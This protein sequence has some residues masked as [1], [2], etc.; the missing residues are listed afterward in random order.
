MYR[1]LSAMLAVSLTGLAL[2]ACGN[3]QPAQQDGIPEGK[4]VATPEQL[5]DIWDQ[6]VALP[7]EQVN[8]ELAHGVA[9]DIATRGAEGIA[10]L[11]RKLDVPAPTPQMVVLSLGVLRKHIKPEH[12]ALLIELAG[13]EKSKA[14][15]TV[16]IDLL[17]SIETPTATAKLAELSNDPDAMIAVVA[18][19]AH[20]PTGDAA[21][22][23]RINSFWDN[24]AVHDSFRQ[25]LM[26]RL[27]EA[28][29][30]LAVGPMCA[31]VTRVDWPTDVRQRVI[32]L[33]GFVNDP[34]AAEALKQAAET[35]P[36][37]ELR[38]Y[39]AKA[40][41]A[42]EA[43]IAAGGEIQTVEVGPDGVH[44]AVMP[45]KAEPGMPD[46]LPAPGTPAPAPAAEPAPA[47]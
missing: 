36:E 12:E 40:A 43:R 34:R 33:L 42:A 29:T 30:L 39:A 17:G 9:E 4:A 15:R 7:K 35:N 16:A 25:E 14:T 28:H 1:I 45:L 21:F 8:F 47:Q 13:P 32:G 18:Y 19:I 24:P 3:K 31:T 22:V 5:L 37:P 11:L 23:E 10:P 20:L 41:A 2:S 46:D 6:L 26:R 44:P 38:E 27:P